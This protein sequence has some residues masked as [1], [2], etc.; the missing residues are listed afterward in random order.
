MNYNDIKKIF[1]TMNILFNT[2]KTISGEERQQDF[3]IDLIGKELKRFEQYIT[4]IEAHLSDQNG[5][6]EGVNDMQCV[7]EARL[8]GKQP[9]AVTCVADSTEKA[10]SGAIDKLKAMLDTMV[11]KIQNH[12]N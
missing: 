2:D 5:K 12:S 9:V 11:G 7:L 10:V 6:K 8:E 4:R 1:Y 3:F